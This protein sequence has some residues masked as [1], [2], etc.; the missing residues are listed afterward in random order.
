LDRYERERSLIQRLFSALSDSAPKYL[1]RSFQLSWQEAASDPEK[2]RVIV[3]QI[4]SL[5][6][7]AVDLLLAKIDGK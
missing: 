7:P 3:D 6:D 1:D 5:T 4:A 2:V